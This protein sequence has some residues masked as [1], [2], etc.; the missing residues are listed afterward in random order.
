MV[1]SVNIK[2]KSAVS[3]SLVSR[4]RYEAKPRSRLRGHFQTISKK[5]SV[6]MKL[7]LGPPT[8]P[9]PPPLPLSVMAKVANSHTWT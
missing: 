5:I 6:I 8:P 7:S 3:A 9:P 2:S 1:A 4:P